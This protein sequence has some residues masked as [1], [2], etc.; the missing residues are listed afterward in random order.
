VIAQLACP[1]TL[2]ASIP[3]LFLALTSVGCGSDQEPCTEGCPDLSG[4][5]AIRN[6]VPVGECPFTPYLL[7]PTVQLLQNDSGQRVVLHVI[8]PSTQLEV[9]LTGDVYA[10]GPNDEAGLLG[11]FQMR[12][13]TLRS[14]SRSS[15]Q[16]VMLEV[17][18]SGS[19][20][21]H[22]GRRVL[23][24]TLRTQ[25]VSSGQACTVSLSVIG[26]GT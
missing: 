17:L 26:E 25:D 20:S 22:E 21:S 14:A 1:M 24:A 8:D 10:P 15:E 3:V 6:A 9:P 12:A 19:V 5:Y 2:R 18:A 11:S 4:V 7:G 16:T 13:R 23:S